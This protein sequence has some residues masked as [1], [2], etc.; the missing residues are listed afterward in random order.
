MHL[1][2]PIVAALAVL[3]AATAARATPAAAA[4][5]YDGKQINLT[6]G[7]GAGGGVDIVARMFAR[8]FGEHIAG[9]RAIVIQNMPGAAGMVAMNRLA[10]TAPKDG[11]AIGYD[12][13]TPLNQVIGLKQMRFDY[14][15]LTMI[16]A[17]R[18]GPYVMFARKDVVPGG[19]THSADIVKAP[20]LIYAGQQPTLVL[21]IHGRMALNLMKAKYK[22]VSGYRSAPEIRIAME[23]GEANVTTHGLQGY[24]AGVEPRYIKQGLFVPLWYFQRRD[25]KGDWVVDPAMKGMPTLLGTYREVYG[26]MPAGTEADALAMVA[27]LYGSV[28]NVVW[29]P[30]GMAPEAVAPLRQAFYA[31]A[32]DPSFQAEQD[33]TFG[34]RYEPVPVAE[35]EQVVAGLSKVDPK[36]VAY[37]KQLMAK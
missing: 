27:D 18:A 12:S 5:Y 6:V 7:F 32:S 34:F 16:G 3:A 17:L 28:A 20:N 22:Y 35:A 2:T 37:F 24:R 33:R 14:A 31:A 36:L 8:A 30:P 29:G 10:N 15:K 26:K 23:R 1:P 19:L 4:D 9:K 21:D 13:W 11:T 25:A